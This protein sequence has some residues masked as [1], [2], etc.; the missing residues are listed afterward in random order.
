M[1]AKVAPPPD[2]SLPAD[3]YSRWRDL[4]KFIAF[5]RETARQ[6]E[7]E[8]RFPKRVHITPRCAAWPN[9]ELHRWAVDPVN[10]R[11]EDYAMLTSTKKQ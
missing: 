4:K 5:C 8:G 10:Y 1:A 7:L 2:E 11:A 6:R 9:R 3:G